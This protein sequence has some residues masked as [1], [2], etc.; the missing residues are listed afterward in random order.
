LKR[1]RLRAT[2]G[3]LRAGSG[4]QSQTEL[5]LAKLENQGDD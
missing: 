1:V 3:A 4:R 2:F 5:M